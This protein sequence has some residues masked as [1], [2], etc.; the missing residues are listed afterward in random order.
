MK[1]TTRAAVSVLLVLVAA[2]LSACQGSPSTG[3]AS[4]LNSMRATKEQQRQI[5]DCVKQEGWDV[6]FD[7]DSGAILSG[8]S[9]DQDAAYS[10]ALDKCNDKL[11]LTFNTP[12]NGEQLKVVY[13]WYQRIASCLKQNDW[14]AP[15]TPSFTSFA[16]T[17]STDPWIPWISIPGPQMAKAT[18]DCPVI[19]EGSGLAK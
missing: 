11:G 15:A 10:A 6:T 17:Y 14:P 18:D 2:S 4:V 8:A 16:D 9:D 1:T 3:D 7:D 5:Y 12:P 19:A 13:R